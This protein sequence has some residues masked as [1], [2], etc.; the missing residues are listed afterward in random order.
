VAPDAR[1][2]DLTHGIPAHD[3]Q[4]GATVLAGAVRFM[5]ERCVYLAVVDPGVG[6]ERRG[7]AVQTAEGSILVGPD[8]GLLSLAWRELGGAVRAHE[9]TDRNVVIEPISRTFHG[10]DI[11]APAAAHLSMGL[12]IEDLGAEIPV[13]ELVE[14][15]F[16]KTEIEAGTIRCAVLSI[17]HFGNIQLTATPED[18]DAAGLGTAQRVAISIGH[19]SEEALRVS[20]FSGAAPGE[21]GL[22]EDSAG[23]LAVA[24]SGGS[25]AK[26]LRAAA[27]DSLT[28]APVR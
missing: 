20:T 12:P 28:L 13:G 7:I 3:I 2:I 4:R 25:A 1:I 27:G 15:S 6:G 23:R 8:N 9:V 24:L 21:L 11:F 22:L 5:P 14:M 17:D 10:R 26:A 16:P 19:R 18:L